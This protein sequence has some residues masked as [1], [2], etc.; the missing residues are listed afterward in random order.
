MFTCSR[1]ERIGMSDDLQKQIGKI[2]LD[3]QK[4]EKETVQNEKKFVTVACAEIER[5]AKTLMRD[6]V[7]NPE[8]TYGKR[9]H[10][11]SMPGNAPAPDSGTLMRSVTHEV[12][13]EGNEVTGLVGSIY[14]NPDYP[15]FL[16]YGTS[17]MK[18]RP[19][20]STAIERSHNFMVQAFQKIMGGK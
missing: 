18:P 17:K 12:T 3:L 20:L 16:E 5:Q 7:V 1:G 6:T 9:G 2:I 8:V 10:H 15:K 14:R 19:W 11:P 13:V 4:K